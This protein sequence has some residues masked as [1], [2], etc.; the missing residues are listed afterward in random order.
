[1]GFFDNFCWLFMA[2]MLAWGLYG[3]MYVFNAKLRQIWSRKRA[4]IGFLLGTIGMM[5]SL[6]SINVSVQLLS[7]IVG[8]IALAPPLKH[9]WKRL[10]YEFFDQLAILGVE[11]GT[12]GGISAKLMVQGGGLPHFC[13]IP[14]DILLCIGVYCLLRLNND[15]NGEREHTSTI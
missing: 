7:S 1:M 3:P 9:I 12:L 4:I 2:S 13:H 14:A 11:V 8:F 5:S 10:T 6:A 15:Q